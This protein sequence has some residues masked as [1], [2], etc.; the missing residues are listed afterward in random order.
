MALAPEDPDRPNVLH[1][2]ALS[3]W[4]RF[5]AHLSCVR[6]QTRRSFITALNVWSPTW[7]PSKRP[8][9]LDETQLSVGDAVFAVGAVANI[10]HTFGGRRLVSPARLL[11]R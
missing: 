1:G 11:S 6:S 9:G 8:K 10:R 4:A 3:R 5:A 2:S 7:S